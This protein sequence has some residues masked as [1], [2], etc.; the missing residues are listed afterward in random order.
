MNMLASIDNNCS[1]SLGLTHLEGLGNLNITEYIRKI[2]AIP[3]LSKEE[4]LDLSNKYIQ[5]ADLKAAAALVTSHLKLVVKVAFA[6]QSSGLLLSDLISEGTLGLMHAVK[7]YKPD[8]GFRLSTYATWW[9]KAYVKEFIL[10]SWSLVKVASTVSQRKLFFSL[11]KIKNKLR[12]IHC[13]DIGYDDFQEIAKSTNASISDIV[14]MDARLSKRDVSLDGIVSHSSDGT[15]CKLVDLLPSNAPS[16][17]AVVI[18]EEETALRKALL[19]QAINSLHPREAEIFVGRILSNPALP[20]RELS[21]AHGI[22]KERVRQIAEKA[23]EK[24][25]A[26]V[27]SNASHLL[28]STDK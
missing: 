8:L 25:K 24:V 27:L 15:P 26:F 23:L 19:Q 12:Q 6:Y 2:N 17:E 1:S 9:I 13:R 11:N 5:F 14:E 4:E 21:E 3:S 16:Q 28:H 7:K 22:S 20:L 18:A 10:R